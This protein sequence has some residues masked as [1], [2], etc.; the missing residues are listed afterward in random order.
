MQSWSYWLTLLLVTI[1]VCKSSFMLFRFT[2]HLRDLL[3]LKKASFFSHGFSVF[4]R[5]FREI[6]QL[7]QKPLL[8]GL[9]ISLSGYWSVN[10]ASCLENQALVLLIIASKLYR[11]TVVVMFSTTFMDSFLKYP[12]SMS[13]LFVPLV[14]A[15]AVLSGKLFWFLLLINHQ[16]LLL[17]NVHRLLDSW[18]LVLR[19]TQWLERK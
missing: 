3:Q 12:E 7:Q 13:L 15:L 16:S 4:K 5:H 14:E 11:H 10:I 19:W 6:L 1:H 8:L 17:V 18:I 2:G 9:S